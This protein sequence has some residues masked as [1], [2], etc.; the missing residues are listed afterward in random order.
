[1]I[2]FA[3]QRANGQDL[4]THLQNAQDNEL[5]EVAHVRGAIAKD[6]HGAFAEWEVQAHGLTR[7]RNYLYSLSIN[8]D[9]AQT[10]LTRE[11]YMDYIAR[12]E[13]R[14]GLDGQPRAVVFHIKN[15][16]EHCH[17]VWSRIDAR[18]E[19]AVQ[20]SFDKDKLMMVTRE[21]A[22]EHGLRLPKGYDRDRDKAAERGDKGRQ[23][24]L[25]EQ[26]QQNASGLSQ[27]DRM[28]AVTDAWRRS[29]SPQAFVN[30]LSD[31]G[32]ILA[33]GKRPYVLIDIDG[34]MNAL[35]KLIADKQIRTKDIRA[36]LA[37]EYPPESLPS[38]E[39]ARKLAAAH[40]SARRDFSKGEARAEKMA[41]LERMQAERRRAAE[42]ARDALGERQRG[43]RQTLADRHARERRALWAQVRDELRQRRR[44]RVARPPTGLAAFLGRVTGMDLIRRKIHQAQDAR[45]LADYRAAR[46]QI[47]LR[48]KQD[49]ADL[50]QVQDMQALD[51][52]RH[53]RNLARIETRERRSL[54]ASLL[55]RTREHAPDRAPTRTPSPAPGLTLDLKPPGRPAMVQKAKNRYV[56]HVEITRPPG[57]TADPAHSSRDP[58][59]PIN[60][61][62]DFERAARD[63]AAKSRGE[64]TRTPDRE[65]GH[66]TRAGP[67]Y[68]PGSRPDGRDGGRGR[69]R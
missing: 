54:E 18:K 69:G 47:A 12:A 22:R 62:H 27:A 36:F 59:D 45:R 20:L 50:K 4:A 39:E 11:Q 55:R 40:R 52:G 33:T 56:H 64:G 38:V 49:R 30:A 13:E 68:I 26:H 1:M 41:R 10:P 7:C 58:D 31:L 9:P 24:T 32:Y 16:R 61:T 35:P 15:G 65:R 25:Y 2:P 67:D 46:D 51:T 29:D 28:A 42:Q 14:L 48:Q 44:D 6:L 53:L 63:P 57:G 3:S 17:V 19:K 23:A 21:F 5:V 37:R 60:P 8:P 43:E 34:H 66:D